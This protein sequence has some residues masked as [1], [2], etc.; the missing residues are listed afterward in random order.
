MNLKSRFTALVA[1]LLVAILSPVALAGVGQVEG[2]IF[3]LFGAPVGPISSPA[4]NSVLTYQSSTGKWIAAAG[5]A[6]P[7]T[8]PWSVVLTNGNTSGGTNPTLTAGDVFVLNDSSSAGLSGATNARLRYNNTTAT[9]Q[10]SVQGGAYTSLIPGTPTLGQVVNAGAVVNSVNATAQITWTTGSNTTQV[11]GPTDLN[12]SFQA[13]SNGTSGNNFFIRGGAGGGGTP[14]YC[15][16]L[17]NLAAGTAPSGFYLYGGNGTGA[18]VSGGTSTV[19]AGVGTGTGTPASLAFNVG[20]IRATAGTTLQTSVAVTT[21]LGA[22]NNT[23]GTTNYLWQ[24][25]PTFADQGVSSTGSPFGSALAVT[26]TLNYTGGTKAEAFTGIFENLS[27]TSDP[28]GPILL[29]DLQ[30]SSATEFNVDT[31]G[32]A[33]ANGSMTIG[34]G[35]SFV[36]LFRTQFQCPGDGQIKFTNNSDNAWV[37]VKYGPDANGTNTNSAATNTQILGQATGNAVGPDWVW[38]DGYVGASGTSIQTQYDRDRICGKVTAS[39]T[40]GTSGTVI[41]L[42]S[43]S[44]ISDSS[45]GGEIQG[46]IDVDDGLHHVSSVAFRLVWAASNR[47]GTTTRQAGTAEVVVS[48]QTTFT[49]LTTTVTATLSGTSVVLNVTPTWSAGT[50]SIVR[51]NWRSMSYGPTLG[52]VQ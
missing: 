51:V 13:G 14:A 35:R 29:M 32:N 28:S 5:G 45:I 50:P 8:S 36:F 37:S 40:P 11:L 38:Q 31:A 3:A 46:D 7:T 21:L 23:S 12:L 20:G 48:D 30:N 18:N 1:I 22:F 42:I 9:L 15:E 47:N 24:I 16:S 27:H 6:G 43:Y 2:V 34:T 33:Q 44:T 25:N 4:N 19:D 10:V 52:T 39:A 41:P 17:G 26:P 49:A